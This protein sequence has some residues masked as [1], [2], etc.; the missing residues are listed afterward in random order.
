MSSVAPDQ[1]AGDLLWLSQR[2]LKKFTVLNT[3]G[4]CIIRAYCFHVRPQLLLNQYDVLPPAMVSASPVLDGFWWNFLCTLWHL[5]TL[6]THEVWFSTVGNNNT[7][8]I[9]T[10]EVMTL[11][12]LPKFNYHGNHKKL[13]NHI[14]LPFILDPVICFPSE[15]IW[16]CGSYRQSIGLLGRGISP[17]ARLLPT[18][19]NN[20]NTE[21]MLTDIHS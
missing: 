4:G 19:N 3:T 5:R 9:W 8:D 1:I 2:L 20:T 7:A 13:I 21:E 15:L 10:C 12:P 17:V 18:H 14:F 16:N 6:K 11:V